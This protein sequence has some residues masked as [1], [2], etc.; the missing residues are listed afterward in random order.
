MQRP[1]ERRVSEILG[2]K[3]SR[4]IG[5]DSAYSSFCA[6]YVLVSGTYHLVASRKRCQKSWNVDRSRD[7][8]RIMPLYVV[9]Q[10]WAYSATIA[11]SFDSVF[12]KRV[13]SAVA[14]FLSASERGLTRSKIR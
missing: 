11:R 10:M 4:K 9:P 3:L 14:F 7:S 5:T 13:Q 2:I 8:I 12:L 1:T 6:M